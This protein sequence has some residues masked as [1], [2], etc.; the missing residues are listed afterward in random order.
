[1]TKEIWFDM[2]G[3]IADLYGVENWL[4]DLL[5]KNERPY[6]SAKPL[7]NLSSLA[8]LLNKL[9]KQ[10]YKIGI[11]S[12]LCKN[13]TADYDDKVIIAKEKWLK[14]H[15]P[16][17]NFDS[18]KIVKYGTY[19]ET[20]CNYS[21]GILFDDEENNRRYWNGIAYDEKNIIEILKGL[22]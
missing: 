2:D 12:W 8:R 16:S 4:A 15:L 14:N 20:V 7:V 3:T 17:V 11:V 6:A 21:K 9:Q 22:K 19:K 1:M 5:A 13:S 10:G 18:V